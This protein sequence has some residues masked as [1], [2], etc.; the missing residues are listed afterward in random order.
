MRTFMPITTTRRGGLSGFE[1]FYN[2]L[3]DFFTGDL[4]RPAHYE[5]FRLDLR[6]NEKEYIIDAELPGVEKKDVKIRFEEGNLTIAVEREEGKAAEKDN[7]VHRERRFTSLARSVHLPDVA[8]EGVKAKLTDGILTV[9]I[10]KAPKKNH[11][12]AIDI[13]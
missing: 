4:S 10:P 9:T 11:E 12:I 1:N 3:D 8:E 5:G 6:D 13:Q 7:Y 2:V